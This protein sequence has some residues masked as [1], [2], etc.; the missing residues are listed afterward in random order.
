MANEALEHPAF[1]QPSDRNAT[2]WRYMDASKFNWFVSSCRLFMASA[3]RLGDPLE[4][5]SPHGELEWWKRQVANS[6]DDNQKQ[7]IKHNRNFISQMTKL[8]RAN[9]F[10]SCWHMCPAENGA[11]WGCYTSSPDSVAIRTTYHAL[12]LA[13]PTYIQIGL[14]R[15]IDYETARL[16]TMNMFEYIMHKDVY[17]A[18]EQELRVVATLPGHK[19]LG[20]DDFL[21]DRFEL[22]AVEGFQVYAPQVKIN[23]LVLGIVL[24][25]KATEKYETTVRKL[26]D[27]N[28]LPA[29]VISRRSLSPQFLV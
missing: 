25:P 3:D 19:E 6:A 11:M 21:A 29:P 4:G 26:C 22:D 17:F 1:P 14:V 18:F 27:D 12:Q 10:V 15:Y 7:I 23:K 24:H 20:Q 5:T 28:G 13:L 9:Y 16:P 8:F 2:I